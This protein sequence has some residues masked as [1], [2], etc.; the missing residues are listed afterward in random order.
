MAQ[1]TINL[2]PTVIAET[3]KLGRKRSFA[4]KISVL[5]ILFAIVII[6]A[7][8]I[9]RVVQLSRVR[10]A[11]MEVELTQTEVATLSKEEG[12]VN[13]LKERIN[14]ISGIIQDDS[15]QTQAF[16]L[17]T[18]LKPQDVRIINLAVNKVQTITLGGEST[19]TSALEEFFNNLTSLEKHKGKIVKVEVQS[20]GQ[21]I[22]GV[23][24]FDLLI[25][26]NGL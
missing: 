12:L 18:S 19:T 7:I 1:I 14:L 15:E 16:N 23:Y 2:L 25:T 11:N 3:Q 8:L 17:I 21:S 22:N 4:I 20:L 10:A 9:Y 5:V 26:L 6:T 13:L 24:K